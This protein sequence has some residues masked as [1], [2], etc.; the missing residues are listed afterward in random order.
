MAST[1]SWT[2]YNGASGA[3]VVASRVEANWK[4]IDDSTTAYSASPITAG[5]N[6]FVKVQALVFA[7]TWNSLSALTYKVSTNAPGTGLTVVAAVLTSAITSSATSSGYSAAST[8]GTSANF[9]T[10]SSPF[11]TGTSSSTASGTMYANAYATQLQTSGSAAPGDLA[12]PVTITATWT[13]S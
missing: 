11:G 2:E 8:S 4:N 12:T 3:T 6:S 9:N 10:S 1:Q 7:G 13:E 5:N